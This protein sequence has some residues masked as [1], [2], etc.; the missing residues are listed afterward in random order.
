MGAKELDRARAQEKRQ[1]ARK[2]K[3]RAKAE[4]RL[5]QEAEKE[6]AEILRHYREMLA[7]KEI[8]EEK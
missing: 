6:A 2:K 1:A 8:E 7:R 3:E 4:K 5:R